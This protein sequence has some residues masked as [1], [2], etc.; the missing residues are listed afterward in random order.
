MGLLR[1]RSVSPEEKFHLR[2][3]LTDGTE[4]VRDVSSLL[5]GLIFEPIRSD[6]AEFHKVRA[7]AGTAVWPNGAD[8]DPDVLIWGGPPPS[9]PSAKPPQFL[10]PKVPSGAGR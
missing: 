5:E 2:L 4:V 10:K 7:A 8:L 6:A 3:T 9:E 1:I